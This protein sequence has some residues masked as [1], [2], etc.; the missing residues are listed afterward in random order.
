[1]ISTERK[2]QKKKVKKKRGSEIHT[3]TELGNALIFWSNIVIF[4][5]INLMAFHSDNIVQSFGRAT[6]KKLSDTWPT[7]TTKIR[8][9][10]TEVGEI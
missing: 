2:K 9:Q 4:P 3:H 8:L 7:C 6:E 5:H 10:I 1:M